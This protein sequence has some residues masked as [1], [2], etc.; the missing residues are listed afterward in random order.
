MQV[1]VRHARKV[2]TV[3]RP[4]LPMYMFLWDDGACDLMRVRNSP[5]VS[6]YLR[7]GKQAAF[8]TEDMIKELTAREN[9]KGVIEL[10]NLLITPCPFKVGEMV[11]IA[12]DS[13]SPFAGLSVL[14]NYRIDEERV[15]VFLNIFG[16][17]S[18]VTMAYADLQ[19]I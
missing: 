1:V 3:I 6:G 7:W 16:Q 11:R 2:Q 17:L 18:Q 19:K 8:A 14:F 4:F 15:A 12:E 9:A 13:Q 10:D 5:G